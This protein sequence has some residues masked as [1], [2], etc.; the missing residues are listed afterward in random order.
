MQANA[1]RRRAPAL[2]RHAARRAQHAAVDVVVDVRDQA[3]I[4]GAG[5]RSASRSLGELHLRR[6][7]LAQ[8][9]EAV[10]VG[11][12]V[13]VLDQARRGGRQR[14]VQMEHAD[15]R[16]AAVDHRHVAQPV[17]RMKPIAS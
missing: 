2:G 7:D 1:H 12:P 10:L 17:R 11:Q 5:T 4:S 3:W 6:L 9:R 8:A 14:V 15:E 13:D 16:A